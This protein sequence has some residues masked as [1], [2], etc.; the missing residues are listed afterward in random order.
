L[1]GGLALLMWVRLRLTL[2]WRIQA[3]LRLLPWRGKRLSARLGYH[4]SCACCALRIGFIA[5]TGTGFAKFLGLIGRFVLP[6][7][8][9]FFRCIP[10]SEFLG[11]RGV[12]RLDSFA[13]LRTSGALLCVRVLVLAKCSL[14]P[15]W[16]AGWTA[17]AAAP[18]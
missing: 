17:I 16:S 5:A 6:I 8:N 18:R 1:R 15:A 11:W 2:A 10:V 14:R 12:P 7:G 4:R 13:R 9:S 3:S